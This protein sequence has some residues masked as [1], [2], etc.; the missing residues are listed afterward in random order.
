M[1][2]YNKS[3]NH[4]TLLLTRQGVELEAI[5][6]VENGEAELRISAMMI[7]DLHI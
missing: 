3:G 6:F 5:D 7:S 1:T 2:S 4:Q